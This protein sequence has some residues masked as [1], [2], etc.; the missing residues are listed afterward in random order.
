VLLAWSAPLVVCRSAA[1]LLPSTESHAS[2]PTLLE[3]FD[4]P[5]GSLS[6]AL[7]DEEVLLRLAQKRGLK[8]GHEL[9][10]RLIARARLRATR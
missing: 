5:T 4:R 9:V 3:R 10:L 1:S 8:G 2:P 6:E 7:E